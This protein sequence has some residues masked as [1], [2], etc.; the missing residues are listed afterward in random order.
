VAEK[1]GYGEPV[2]IRF[3]DTDSLLFSRASR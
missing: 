2:Q 3:N 1:A